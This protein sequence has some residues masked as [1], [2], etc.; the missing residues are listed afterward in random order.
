MGGVMVGELCGEHHKPA[1]DPSCD[2]GIQRAW[3]Y[4]NDPALSNLKFSKSGGKIPAL[5]NETSLPLGAGA[6][7]KI[8]EDLKNRG[9]ML[10]RNSTTITKGNGSH[11]GI[12][13]FQDFKGDTAKLWNRD[14]SGQ[15]S[16][17][18]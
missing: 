12:S 8:M 9:G 18:P 6:Q 1:A 15:M 14:A 4:S 13:I 3:L 11:Y 16:V 10:Y 7:M 17:R 2:T 5:D